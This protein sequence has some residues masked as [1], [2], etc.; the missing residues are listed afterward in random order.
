MHQFQNQEQSIRFHGGQVL[1]IADN[2]FGN[3]DLGR[4]AERLV[5]NRVRFLPAFLRLQK[6]W[7]IEKLRIDLLQ[8]DK[9]SDVDGMRGF[10]PDL[11]EI[12]RFHDDVA[13]TLVLEA[14]YNL[15]GRYFF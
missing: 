4:A 10:D 7:L 12:L 6:I 11:L 5:Q 2:D 8:L 1:A 13:A 15:I 14:F 3:A 9:V